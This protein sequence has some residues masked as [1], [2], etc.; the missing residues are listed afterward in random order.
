MTKGFEKHC[1][2]CN[3]LL[4]YSGEHDAYFCTEC[5]EWIE[6]KCINDNCIFCSGRP[7]KP[8]E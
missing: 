8:K 4:E 6:V 1:P 2:D 7:E 3:T 5:N